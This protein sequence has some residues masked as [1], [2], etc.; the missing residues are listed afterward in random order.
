M[1][2]K[3]FS[4]SDEHLTLL[5][6]CASLLE[7]QNFHDTI[8]L[9]HGDKTFFLNKSP[10]HDWEYVFPKNSKVELEQIDFTH[11]ITSAS[12]NCTETPEFFELNLSENFREILDLVKE[13][14]MLDI[15]HVTTNGAKTP[16]VVKVLSFPSWQNE[17]GVNFFRNRGI[18]KGVYYCNSLRQA[19]LELIAR[20]LMYDECDLDDWQ[21]YNLNSLDY[22]PD[23]GGF[24]FE[25]TVEQQINESFSSFVEVLSR[26]QKFIFQDI[27]E[28]LNSEPSITFTDFFSQ[29]LA[30]QT[31]PDLK[32][33]LEQEFFQPFVDDSDN[34][35]SESKWWVT[36]IAVI[37]HVEKLE[38]DPSFGTVTS[39]ASKTYDLFELRENWKRTNFE[40]LSA[41]AYLKRLADQAKLLPKH[42]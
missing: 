21:T 29:S 28:Y 36:P 23:L 24:V 10:Y 5:K 37:F 22:N 32:E 42:N 8:L 20:P 39:E 18:T 25:M 1:N 9:E 3:A 7:S 15:L 41:T 26:L 33:K 34:L 12:E 38:I 11:A 19:A 14:H 17:P 31:Q 27:F 13:N 6:L 40:T 16:E 2:L 4:A 30:L 35:A